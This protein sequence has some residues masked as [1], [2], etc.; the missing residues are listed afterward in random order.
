MRRAMTRIDFY[1]L[2]SSTPGRR[3]TVVC[4]LAEKAAGQ[5]QRVFI[6]ADDASLLES[7]DERLWTF[8]A[9]SFVAHRLLAADDTGS[10][11]G[12]Q[13]GGQSGNSTDSDPVQLSLGQPGADRNLLI[14]LASEVPH[15][16]SRFERTLEVVDQTEAIRN[17]G[18]A[19]YRYYKSR[20]Y[21]MKHHSL[22]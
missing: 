1:V 16:F 7:L 19:R 21:P 18:R 3:Q 5:G 4:K 2:D 15:F 6:H 11:V 8:R 17:S 22:G 13:S 9:N 12:G 14:N 10:P 20:G